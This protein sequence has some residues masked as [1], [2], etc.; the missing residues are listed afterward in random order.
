[1]RTKLGL[2]GLCAVVVGIM[3]MSAGAAQGAT[4]SWL[5]LNSTHTTATELKA[6]LVG[7]KDTDL[8][9][10]AELAGLKVTITCG[11]FALNG[12]NLEVG[13]KLTEGGKVSFSECAI[14]KKG[15]LEEKD[16]RCT[17]KSAG[18]AA[19]TIE[20]G[21]GKGELVLIGGVVET[22]VEPKAGPTG[23][24]ATI[25]FE[26]AECPYPESNQVHGTLVLKDCLGIPTTHKVTH[27]VEGDALN[28]LLYVGGHSAKQLEVT[29][30]HGS[31]F[32]SLGKGAVDHTGLEWAAMDV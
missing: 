32:I 31:A 29:K 5:I 23:T 17:V 24:F 19:G 21:E 16:T 11:K 8:T 7:T 10:L 4:L 12:V 9:L 13:G 14:Y 22:K 26:G 15:T 28:T 1:M 20:T 3:S 25:R 18:A 2:L 27:L 6:L 30:I